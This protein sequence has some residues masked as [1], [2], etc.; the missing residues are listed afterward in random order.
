MRNAIMGT[1]DHFEII[2]SLDLGRFHKE[3]TL[4]TIWTIQTK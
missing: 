2:D 4:Q 1:A 3:R